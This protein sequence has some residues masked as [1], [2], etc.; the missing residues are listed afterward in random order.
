M[1]PTI[2]GP[3]FR[4]LPALIPEVYLAGLSARQ[5]AARVRARRVGAVARPA[6]HAKSRRSVAGVA[7]C[8]LE[9][10]AVRAGDHAR[11]A[12]PAGDHPRG[13]CAPRGLRAHA[14]RVPADNA[15]TFVAPAREAA[16]LGTRPVAR[17]REP[18]VPGPRLDA[19]L[20]A[21]RDRARGR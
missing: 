6:G 17:A 1:R 19:T 21:G 2:T 14:R 5:P 13:S 15:A 4:V 7:S 8:P 20:A 9:P 11:T 10:A 18:A 12:R 16:S 3:R